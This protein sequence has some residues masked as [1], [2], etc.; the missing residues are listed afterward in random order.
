VGDG[1]Q[2][3]EAWERERFD[4]VL[5]DVQMPEMDGVSATRAIRAREAALGRPRTPI[6]ALSANAMT[7][8]VREYLAAGMDGH[9][10]K[11]IAIEQLAEVLEAVLTGQAPV[12]Q[13]MD[14][15]SA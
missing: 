4:L 13:T 10:A 1:R 6:V 9:V 15:A 7:H 14:Q 5:M 12:E 2:A 11:P 8:Q 3:V